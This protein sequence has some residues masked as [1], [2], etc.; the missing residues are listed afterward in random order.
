MKSYPVIL[1]IILYQL[2]WFGCVFFQDK[3]LLPG[4]VLIVLHLLLCKDKSQELAVVAYCASMGLVMD[5]TL[6]L[7]GIF[8]FTAT[9][10]F[11]PIPLWL[12]LIWV[13]FAGTLRHGLR[14]FMERPLLALSAAAIGAPFIYH[15]A[16]RFGA[17]SFP[18][19][20]VVTGVVVSAVWFFLMMMFLLFTKLLSREVK[21]VPHNL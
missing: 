17:V 14:F 20:P 12:I 11:L 2:V 15:T 9:P 7:V 1:N 4:V 3:F 8:E 10:S 21:P 16:S 6:T 5:A 18:V 13:G 19:G